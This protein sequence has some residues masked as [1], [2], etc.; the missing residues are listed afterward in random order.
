MFVHLRMLLW[1]VI[2]LPL[3]S[4]I[5]LQTPTP[6][7]T[8]VYVGYPRESNIVHIS[9][10]MKVTWM[11]LQMYTVSLSVMFSCVYSKKRSHHAG[12]YI[13]IEYM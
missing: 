13:I 11:T 5:R 2:V 6:S 12:V 8:Y 7:C 1:S 10:Y 3:L 4:T 9:V